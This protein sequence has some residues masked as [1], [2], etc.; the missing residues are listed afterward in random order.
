MKGF[1]FFF[2]FFFFCFCF[3]FSVLD[4]RV[5]IYIRYVG[6]HSCFRHVG[7]KLTRLLIM[8]NQVDLVRFKF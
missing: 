7:L 1:F 6:D 2:F 3:F 4:F 5:L 8:S